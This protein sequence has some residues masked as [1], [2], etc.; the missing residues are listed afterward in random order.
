MRQDLG[1]WPTEFAD[2]MRAAGPAMLSWW[3]SAE[4][5]AQLFIEMAEKTSASTSCMKCAA[6][7]MAAAM[8]S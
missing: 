1:N 4:T 5:C 2:S 6:S 3:D 8:H 7:S